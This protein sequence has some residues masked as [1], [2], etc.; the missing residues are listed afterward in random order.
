MRK[1]FIGTMVVCL[2]G[3]LT[4]GAVL[5]WNGSATSP[6]SATAGSVSIAFNSYAPT[7]NPVIPND[8][9]ILVA[10]TGFTNNGDIAVKPNAVSPGSASV[11]G[12]SAGSNC[13]AGNFLTPRPNTVGT[14]GGYVGPAGT[15]GGDA[16]HVH[17]QMKSG[18][19][20][21]CQGVTID[22]SVTIN[23]TT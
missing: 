14:N 10:T 4:I 20:D 17:V 8:T 6:R 21:A 16:F 13:T 22:Y 18:A 15:S 5:A 9:D 12:T 7:A 11:T 3:A 19:V 2:L 23:V 1:L